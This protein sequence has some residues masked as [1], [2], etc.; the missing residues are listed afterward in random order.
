M[1]IPISKFLSLTLLL[2]STPTF[3]ENAVTEAYEYVKTKATDVIEFRTNTEKK[4]INAIPQAL[5]FKPIFDT[6]THACD[7]I[8]I[9]PVHKKAFA[10]EFQ[11]D[12]EEVTNE[13]IQ[14]EISKK[15][16][17][18]PRDFKQFQKDAAL[19]AITDHYEKALNKKSSY[20][21]KIKKEFGEIENGEGINPGAESTR[22][23]F[24]AARALHEI[25]IPAIVAHKKD[26]KSINLDEALNYAVAVSPLLS[27]V[28]DELKQMVIA[29]S[30]RPKSHPEDLVRVED[31]DAVGLAKLLNQATHKAA[32]F[33]TSEQFS[34]NEF[35][36]LMRNTSHLKEHERGVK[37]EEKREQFIDKLIVNNPVMASEVIDGIKLTDKGTE[38]IP[39][40]FSVLSK[41]LCE[42]ESDKYEKDASD[43]QLNFIA[44]AV[45]TPIAFIGSGIGAMAM[46]SHALYSLKVDVPEA[47]QTCEKMKGDFQSENALELSEA[48]QTPYDQLP[49]TLSN[50]QAQAIA[51]DECH[52]AASLNKGFAY[53]NVALAGMGYSGISKAASSFANKNKILLSLVP[54]ATKGMKAVEIF[55][56]GRGAVMT[57]TGAYMTGSEL[58]TAC[59]GEKVDKERCRVAKLQFLQTVIVAAGSGVSTYSAYKQ[60]SPK[61]TTPVVQKRISKIVKLSPEKATNT[62]PKITRSLP[63]Q[64]GKEVEGEIIEIPTLSPA[65]NKVGGV[66]L[67][68]RPLTAA[69]KLQIKKN[70]DAMPA[71]PSI[72]P[73]RKDELLVIQKNSRD[74]AVK[75]KGEVQVSRPSG[76]GVKTPENPVLKKNFVEGMKKSA[77]HTEVTTSQ[78]KKE[79][80]EKLQFG[81]SVEYFDPITKKPATMVYVGEKN[82]NK[83][84]SR[85]PVKYLGGSKTELSSE[86][87][88]KSTGDD[89]PIFIGRPNKASGNSGVESSLVLPEKGNYLTTG[90]RGSNE[91]ISFP[92]KVLM[93]ADALKA[94]STSGGEAKPKIEVVVLG[95]EKTGGLKDLIK[96]DRLLIMLPDGTV[97][98][99]NMTMQSS[100]FGKEKAALTPLVTPA[101]E[102]FEP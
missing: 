21:L 24:D 52:R 17:M 96:Q 3:A 4:I 22:L 40:P 45:S 93:S 57:G 71:P 5:G 29:S 101:P 6:K 54:G 2:Q 50:A 60:N 62:L 92:A 84:F 72:A 77:A 32:S 37:F 87:F 20:L 80:F 99:V 76:L 19:L 39:T 34:V 64:H 86:V 95:R 18:E 8:G 10:Q 48:L 41:T 79:V 25:A 7:S 69:E 70:V 28:K 75:N 30:Q 66:E 89:S 81:D 33:V 43:V 46:M 14:T 42:L 98:K 53:V 91:K 61:V 35:N 82:G 51:L 13:K 55:Y 74:L 26:P 68:N 56:V 36:D 94:K 31:F 85:D 78:A 15:L 67:P 97:K 65:N 16:G 73:V 11:C 44:R 27:F 88:L 83:V 90:A 102:W 49:K 38:Y 63:N 100:G 12:S 1:K 23:M 9:Q 58:H 47:Y 59:S